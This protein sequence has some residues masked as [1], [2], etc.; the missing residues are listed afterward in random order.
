MNLISTFSLLIC[1][2]VLPVRS[3]AQSPR[4]LID[5]IMTAVRGNQVT[6]VNLRQIYDPAQATAIMQSL[7][8][9]F[10]DSLWTVRSRSLALGTRAA[11][12]SGH[13]ALCQNMIARLLD[14][15]KDAHPTVRRQAAGLLRQFRKEDFNEVSRAR[16]R[17]LLTQ[18][19][20][21]LGSLALL[22]GYLDLPAT[23]P[24]LRSW[25]N[26]QDTS[27]ANRF[28]IRQALARMGDVSSLDYFTRRI[29]TVSLTGVVLEELGPVL[30][31]I[32]QPATI[33][34]LIDLIKG[35]QTNCFSPNPDYEAGI[36]CAYL[37]ME[38]LAPTLT[39]FPIPFS[40]GILETDDHETALREV[41]N[42][43]ESLGGD[44]P[45][46]RDNY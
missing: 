12:H 34:Y 46:R 24:I 6:P 27:P 26:Q 44:Y 14:A 10:T 7:Y 20:I 42:W 41:R 35:S 9:Y 33:Q 17:Q 32:R 29:S 11:V 13:T 4:T 5:Q 36:P 18:R 16:I 38:Y 25:L 40:D 31:Y 43:L 22:A 21:P 15:L 28:Y 8:P 23:R 45:I 30:A 37:A 2:L 39:G 19:G 1:L 3:A